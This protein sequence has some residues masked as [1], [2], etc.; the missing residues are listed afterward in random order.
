MRVPLALLVA[1]PAF[2]KE[3]EGVTAPP[4]IQVEGK[5]LSLMAWACAR[6]SG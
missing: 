5:P 3:R 4:T 2:A 6:S 1:L